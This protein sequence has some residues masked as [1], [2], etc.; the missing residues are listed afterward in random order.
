MR[1]RNSSSR[2]RRT[3]T[4][5]RLSRSRQTRTTARFGSSRPERP[6]RHVPQSKPAQPSPVEQR[7]A[8]RESRLTRA[9]LRRTA[10]TKRAAVLGIVVC[11]LVLTLAYPLRS[12]LS[13]RSQIRD[14]AAQNAQDRAQVAQLQQSVDRYKDPKY[15][16]QL[17]R[18]RLHYQFPG[19]KVYYLRPAPQA[20]P[21][22]HREGHTQVPV[23]PE[24]AWYDQLWG[25]AVSSGK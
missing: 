17:A 16:E 19:D 24:T 12:F 2:F 25:S 18:T 14:V 1:R 11:M 7:R 3:T 13:Q 21:V 5:L 10:L 15:I 6:G 8:R 9:A 4:S 22:I 23:T 20:A